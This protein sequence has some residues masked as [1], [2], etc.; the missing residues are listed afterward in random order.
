MKR[1]D[2]KTRLIGALQ[3]VDNLV[4]ILDDNPSKDYL[5]NQLFRIKCELDRQ[6]SCMTK[7]SP[8]EYIPPE[9]K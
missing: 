3:Q 8:Y 2:E 6:I 1:M 7:T 9:I 4:M 5:Y